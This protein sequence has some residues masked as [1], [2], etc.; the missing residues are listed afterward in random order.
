M[1]AKINDIRTGH[2]LTSKSNTAILFQTQNELYLSYYDTMKNLSPD[3]ITQ[4]EIGKIELVRGCK[5]KAEKN[6]YFFY[7][8]FDLDT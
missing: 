3:P 5:K 4:V 1:R 7:A 6:D 8:D 2:L